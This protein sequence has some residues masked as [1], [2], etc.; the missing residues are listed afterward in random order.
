MSGTIK[1]SLKTISI[2]RFFKINWRFQK[3]RKLQFLKSIHFRL[4]APLYS[5]DWKIVILEIM[6]LW[7]TGVMQTLQNIKTSVGVWELAVDLK[8]KNFVQYKY[9]IFDE[10]KV[11]YCSRIRRKQI[12]FPKSRC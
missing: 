1:I 11:G 6:K 5:P 7:E 4:E 9:R 2:I 10:K 8:N 3:Q 12:G